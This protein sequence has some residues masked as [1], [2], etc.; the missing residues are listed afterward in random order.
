MIFQ[1][2]I[3]NDFEPKKMPHLTTKEFESHENPKSLKNHTCDTKIVCK[4][5]HFQEVKYHGHFTR[6]YWGETYN[7]ICNLRYVILCEVPII[8]HNGSNVKL[9][10]KLQLL[11]WTW[12]S[13][14]KQS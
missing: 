11:Q 3:V 8:M 4:N 12:E 14:N 7:S 10:I 6:K 9:E 13:G 5:I 2:L 1:G